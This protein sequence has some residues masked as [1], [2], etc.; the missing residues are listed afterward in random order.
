MKQEIAA[1]FKLGLDINENKTKTK[2]RRE[3]LKDA[4]KL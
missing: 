3:I 1:I 2:R 4:K